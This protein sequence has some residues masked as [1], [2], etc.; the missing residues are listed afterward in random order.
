[1]FLKKL[2]NS[3]LGRATFHF[4]AIGKATRFQCALVRKSTRKGARKPKPKYSRCGSTKTYAHLASGT[5]VFY[6]RAVGPGGTQRNPLTETFSISI[7][8]ARKRHA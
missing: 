4:K 1:M 6:V 2:I 7:H 8:K 3:R 5:Y